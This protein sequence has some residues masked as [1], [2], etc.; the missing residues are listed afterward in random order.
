M[1]YLAIDYG[2]KRT[3]LAICD[4]SETI[5]SPLIVLANDKNIIQKIKETVEKETV[6]EIVLGL[7]LN[8]DGSSG[9]QVQ[10]VL[11]FA[12][13][14]KKQINIPVNLQDERLSSAAAEEKIAAA[15]FTIGKKRKYLDAIAAAHILE[16]FI[17][18]KG[19][20]G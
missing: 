15:D 6:S 18:A 16:S 20:K 17:E 5:C 19:R 10:L 2:N 13:R 7:P 4:A 8:M 1:R 11:K 9:P 14:L 12:E 3:G